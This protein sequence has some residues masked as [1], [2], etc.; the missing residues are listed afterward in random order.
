MEHCTYIEPYAGGAGAALELLFH[1]KVE[2]IIINDFDRSIYAI[3]HSILNNTNELIDRIH[4]SKLNLKEW[5]QIKNVYKN[6][7]SKLIELGFA[8]FYLNRTNRSGIISGGPIGGT[9]Q[10]GN[11]KID[12]RFNKKNLIERIE[13]ISL[14]KKRIKV[15]NMDGVELMKKYLTIENKLFY[16]DPPY[17]VKGSSLY[18][19]H[20]KEKD[21]KKLSKFLNSSFRQNWILT[22]DN[23]EAIRKLYPKRRQ[24]IFDLN[25]HAAKPRKGDEVMIFSDSIKSFH[26]PEK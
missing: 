8:S 21:H 6:K 2:K 25:Y 7:K 9:S 19:N 18:L 14:Y 3:W 26:L 13:K 10:K 22:Y 11:W 15:H 17:Y 23:V 20:Y 5:H 24:Q 1:E 12:A 16:V 4:S